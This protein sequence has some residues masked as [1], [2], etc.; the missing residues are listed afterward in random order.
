MAGKSMRESGPGV[1]GTG[2]ECGGR[3]LEHYSAVNAPRSPT[4]A[5]ER[6][7]R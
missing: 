5:F 2:N 6:T 4:L 7:H 1:R 3:G